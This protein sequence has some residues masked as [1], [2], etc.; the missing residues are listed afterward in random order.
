[1]RDKDVASEKR[2]EESRDQ[3]GRRGR[4]AGKGQRYTDDDCA[5]R[6]LSFTGKRVQ[7]QTQFLS[8]LHVHGTRDYML[9]LQQRAPPRKHNPK[10]EMSPRVG[11]SKQPVTPCRL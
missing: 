9:D 6:A 1:M 8:H 7:Q 4:E 5:S 2:G 10:T 3:E 11:Y